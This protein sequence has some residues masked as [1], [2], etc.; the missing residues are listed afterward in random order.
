MRAEMG[1]D[2][3]KAAKILDSILDE[4]EA[5]NQAKKRKIAMLKVKHLQSASDKRMPCY[6]STPLSGFY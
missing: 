3:E 6:Q 5:N 4:D 2:Y 1:E